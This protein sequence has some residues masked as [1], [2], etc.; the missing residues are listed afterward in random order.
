MKLLGFRGISSREQWY[1]MTGRMRQV[2]R[3]ACFLTLIVVSAGEVGGGEKS[4]D[5]KASS[6]DANAQRVSKLQKILKADRDR[7]QELRGETKKFDGEFK[8]TTKEF[9][10]LDQDLTAKKKRL[11]E[12]AKSNPKGDEAKTLK[13]EVGDLE[14]R[15]NSARERLGLAIERRKAVQPQIETLE[16]KIQLESKALEE[17]SGA[18]V[19]KVDPGKVSPPKESPTPGKVDAKKGPPS[20]ESKESKD[21]AK[22]DE[23]ADA[24][25]DEARKDLATKQSA[26]GTAEKSVQRIDHAVELFD[27]DLKLEQQLLATAGKVKQNAEKNL[28]TLDGQL[29]DP[30]KDLPASAIERMREERGVA[31]TRLDEAAQEIKQRGTRIAELETQLVAL[32]AAKEAALE[33][34]RARQSEAESAQRW[35]DFLENPMAPHKI[36]RW[37]LSRGPRILLVIAFIVFLWWLAK[38]AG[39]RLIR[40]MMQQGRKA[41]QHEERTDT[42][43]RVFTNALGI[44]A[45]TVGVL[46]VLQTGGLDVTVLLGGAAI[47]GM[48]IAFGAQNLMKDYFYGFII[49]MENQYTVG[50][51]IRIGNTSGTV[52]HVTLRM[53]VLRD[54]EGV[55]HF[56]PHSEVTKVSN[57][58]HGWSRALF[59]I[60]VG[61]KEDVNSVMD[62]LVKLGKEMREDEN[63]SSMILDDPEMLGVDALGDSGVIIKFFLKT[64]PLKQW[65]VR[66]E[67]LCRIKNAFD[68]QGIEIPFPSRTIYHRNLGNGMPAEIAGPVPAPKVRQH[69]G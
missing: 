49:L 3:T 4:K 12:I 65:N 57:M 44:L 54:L 22:K 2:W 31:Q 30:P 67:L 27:K 68:E 42:L 32:R 69:A 33:G 18:A 66:R 34:L 50:N 5:T 8:S 63:F 40:R 45:I 64:R 13:K 20:L 21:P 59:D 24:T 60:A 1:A 10:Q 6:L 36:L 56:I 46:A 7:L 39:R 61:Y 37:A 35:L 17:F 19:P 51:V 9:D 53:T 62:L 48:A 29:K 41:L 16:E 28:A 55:A 23:P 58:T 47:F 25:A 11:E 26:L 52:E 15:W 14:V 38:V 43:V